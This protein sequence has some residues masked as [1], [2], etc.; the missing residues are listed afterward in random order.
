MTRDLVKL[1]CSIIMISILSHVYEYRLDPARQWNHV[2]EVKPNDGRQERLSNVFR[3]I[4][5][6]I[7]GSHTIE[8]ILYYIK[9]PIK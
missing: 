8:K 2:L 3:K 4:I 6:L 5:K 9:P 7:E 1:I